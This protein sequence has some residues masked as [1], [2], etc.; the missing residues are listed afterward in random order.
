MCTIDILKSKTYSINR[1]S[2]GGFSIIFIRESFVYSVRY[3]EK[4]SRFFFGKWGRY[5]D[6]EINISESIRRYLALKCKQ[7]SKYRKNSN[8]FC[9][10]SNVLCP[11]SNFFLSFQLGNENKV[12]GLESLAFSRHKSTER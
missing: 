9:P 12:Q 11:T 8:C 1:F 5:G 4:F 2:G 6:M 3:M 7:Q 10:S